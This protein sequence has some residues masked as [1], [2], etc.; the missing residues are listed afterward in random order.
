MNNLYYI[1]K[2]LLNS[3]TNSKHKPPQLPPPDSRDINDN[4]RHEK[5]P[6]SPKIENINP[7][8]KVSEPSTI[9]SQNDENQLSK[10][11]KM[12][13]NALASLRDNDTFE[14]N[15]PYPSPKSL[16]IY[17][18]IIKTLSSE[19]QYWDASNPD[20]LKEI[21]RLEEIINKCKEIINQITSPTTQQS[22]TGLIDESTK[23]IFATT[24][25]GRV[26]FIEDLKKI[27]SEYYPDLKS[28]L[29]NIKNYQTIAGNNE[30]Y[31]F[32]NSSNDVLQNIREVKGFKTRIYFEPLNS[33]CM[34]IYMVCLKKEDW[35]SSSFNKLVQRLSHQKKQYY[36]IKSILD[37]GD[38]TNI[39]SLLKKHGVNEQTIINI[40]NSRERGGNDNESQF[41]Q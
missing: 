40:L 10:T 25:S 3:F 36:N 6:S 18:G 1:L 32:L 14:V 21:K 7:T 20:E 37:S 9:W 4:T 11:I 34:Y 28:L 27:S 38:T 2:N 39:D 16:P 29:I 12:Y 5:S 33:D 17:S 22:N 26:R 35:S 8:P 19:I 15:L 31:R 41:Q 23:L 24:P 13:S 30:K